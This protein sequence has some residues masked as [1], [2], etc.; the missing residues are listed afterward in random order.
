METGRWHTIQK[1]DSEVRSRKEKD[2]LI[3]R[4]KERMVNQCVLII[5]GIFLFTNVIRNIL[6]I[7]S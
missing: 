2:R 4:V 5:T 6:E 7:N 1:E 3:V